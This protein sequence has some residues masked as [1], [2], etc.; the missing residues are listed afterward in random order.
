MSLGEFIDIHKSIREK[1]E[2]F[3]QQDQVPNILFHGLCGGGKRTLVKEFINKL[4]NIE[5][6][7]MVMY[8]DCEY[9]K[10]IKFIR[11]EVNYFYENELQ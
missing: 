11:D 10:G 7:D 3:V 8:V 5:Q 6:G 1:L 2:K 4:Y 9:G